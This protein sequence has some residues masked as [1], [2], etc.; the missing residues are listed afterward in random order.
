MRN[1]H[2]SSPNT[3]SFIS[4]HKETIKSHKKDEPLPV[5]KVSFI[6][7]LAGIFCCTSSISMDSNEERKKS[8]K[9]NET[10]MIQP[11][12][13]DPNKSYGTLPCVN[14]SPSY[15]INSLLGSNNKKKKG[16]QKISHKSIYHLKNFKKNKFSER[17]GKNENQLIFL[18]SENGKKFVLAKYK[19][20]ELYCDSNESYLDGTID[21][22]MNKFNLP[23]IDPVVTMVK[24]NK[25]TSSNYSFAEKSSTLKTGESLL[26]SEEYNLSRNLFDE[27]LKNYQFKNIQTIFERKMKI[28]CENYELLMHEKVLALINKKIRN[29]NFILDAFCGMGMNSIEVN[30][31]KI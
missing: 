2:Y 12:L 15:N 3:N 5:K 1:S 22:D 27:K 6:K 4:Q 31:N 10:P 7:K 24:K 19:I 11:P 8:F 9:K 18:K 29:F 20:I 25:K 14:E 28:N 30:L 16:R 26:F 13:L 21:K 17:N 23:F